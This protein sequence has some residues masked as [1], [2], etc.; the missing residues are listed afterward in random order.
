MS[1]SASEA[2]RLF[3]MGKAGD[4]ELLDRAGHAWPADQE[5][6]R[7]S[8]AEVARYARISAYRSEQGLASE[9]QARH[10]AAASLTGNLRSLCLSLQPAF[11]ML[12]SRKHYRGAHAVLDAMGAIAGACS[13]DGPPEAALVDRIL[14]ER[15]AYLYRIEERWEES[16]VWY[17]RA[18]D[19][20]DRGTRS[21]AKV[22]GGLAL[23]KWLAG[24][25]VEDA[26]A[27]FKSLVELSQPWRNDVFEAATS[28]LAAAR[29]GN[30][31]ASVPFDLV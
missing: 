23:A 17:Q 10:V 18:L 14:A 12:V 9:W 28:N 29:S 5:A 26:V 3:E 2:E 15:R 21:F 13:V 22:R 19:L 27:E 30:H 4:A 20:C 7:P 31:T 25:P 24:G 1:M 8:D 6:L 11:F 16:I